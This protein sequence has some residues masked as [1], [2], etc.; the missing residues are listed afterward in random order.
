MA[1]RW[2][3]E[4]GT[5]RPTRAAPRRVAA[6]LVTVFALALSAT[7]AAAYTDPIWKPDYKAA[8]AYAKSH[9][10]DSQ[11]IAFSLRTHMHLWNYRASET[12]PSAS[13]VKVMIL[14][15]YLRRGSVKNS[16]LTGDQRYNLERMIEYSDDQAT[17]RLFRHVGRGGLYNLAHTVGMKHFSNSCSSPPSSACWGR[18]QIDAEDQSLFLLNLEKYLPSKHRSYALSLMRH[19]HRGNWGIGEVHPAGWQVMF[20]S[21]WGLGTGW[22][23]NQVALLRYGSMRIGVAVLSYHNRPDYNSGG[24]HPYGK[25]LL[26]GLF[27]RLLKGLGKNSLVE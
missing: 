17:D 8:K 16:D 15:A 22:V 25:R 18:S 27:Q 2:N 26:K 23:D 24:S 9:R 5:V 4:A 19:I 11:I 13:A 12:E 7:P 6:L 21:G 10:G 20:K 14:T 1:R 3:T